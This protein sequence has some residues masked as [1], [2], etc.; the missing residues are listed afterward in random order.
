MNKSIVGVILLPVWVLWPMADAKAQT[1]VPAD[2]VVK[3]LYTLLL[4]RPYR[5]GESHWPQRLQQGDLTVRGVLRHIAMS[6]EME[7]QINALPPATGADELYRRIL[8][9][10]I[11]K[12][13]L[14]A[15][16]Q[17][18]ASRP[19][20]FDVFVL[21]LIASPEYLSSFGENGV[22]EY[23][24]ATQ[25][26]AQ[27]PSGILF[28]HKFCDLLKGYDHTYF[29]GSQHIETSVILRPDGTISGSYRY[30]NDSVWG[31]CGGVGIAV[32][33]AGNRIIQ[34]FTPP[35]G[36]IGGKTP[37]GH[38]NSRTVPGGAR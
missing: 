19:E 12:E 33:G 34:A 22:P 30:E 16:T 35:S 13:V 7:R 20:Q 18:L 27:S 31:F 29:R 2:D 36:C 11:E 14:D 9:R 5:S 25:A 38:A 10:G 28:Q 6:R 37:G 15:R 26:R 17:Q 23:A 32:L 24:Y 4:K 21:G 8:A 3:S 1:C